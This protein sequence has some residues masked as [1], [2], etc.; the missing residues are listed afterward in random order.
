MSQ[1]IV[2]MRQKAGHTMLVDIKGDNMKLLGIEIT[3]E[4]FDRL[5]CDQSDGKEL[6]VIDGKVVAVEHEPTQDELLELELIDLY[7]WFEEYDNQV[8]QYNRCQR[9]GIEY[10]KDIKQLD[11]QAKV[12]ADRITEIRKDLTLC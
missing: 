11:N 2:V 1:V 12:N 10:D 9:L 8:K 5:M 6:K 7:K 3:F 4:E